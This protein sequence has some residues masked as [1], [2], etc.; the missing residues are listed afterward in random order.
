MKR[1]LIVLGLAAN[2]IISSSL[3]AGTIGAVMAL[4]ERH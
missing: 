2:S 4:P 1:T 3:F